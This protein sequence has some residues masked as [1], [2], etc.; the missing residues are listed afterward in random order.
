MSNIV[1]KFTKS[2]KEYQ[3]KLESLKDE[4]EQQ[5]LREDIYVNNKTNLHNENL[6]LKKKVEE[7]EKKI[8]TITDFFGKV[9]N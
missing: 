5:K 8:K 3:A 7:Y 2:A 4:L 1:Y 6:N 9:G